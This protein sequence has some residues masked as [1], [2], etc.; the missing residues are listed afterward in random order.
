MLSSV[1]NSDRA[2]NVN[3]AIMRTFTRLRKML[4]THKDLRRKIEAMEIKYDEQ[5]RIV[6]EAITQIIEED[7]KPKKK[8][9]YIGQKCRIEPLLPNHFKKKEVQNEGKD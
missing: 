7:K 4:I 1:L 3:I 2:I 5:F 6:F 9:G 8:I